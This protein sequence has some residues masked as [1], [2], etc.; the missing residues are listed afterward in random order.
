MSSFW[1]LWISLITIFTI[2]ASFWLLL[3]NR[4]ESGEKETTGHVYDGIEEYN[5]PL[6]AWWLWMFILTLIF[7]I[8]YLIA[9]PGLGNFKGVLNWSQISEYESEV[10]EAT[11]K[12]EPLFDEYA[13]VPID[14]LIGNEKAMRMGQR[15][16]ANNC[17]QCHGSDARGTFGFPNLADNDWLYGGAPDNIV[18]GIALG[19]TGT[20]PAWGPMLSDEQS[21][22]VVQHVR[23][24]SGLDD[25]SEA[26]AQV[27]GMFCQA[28]H[29]P[30]AKGMQM[31][32]APDLTDDIWLYGSS[33]ELISNAVENGLSGLMPAHNELLTESRIHLV[34]AYV[35][36]LSNKAESPPAENE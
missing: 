9:Y 20:M 3:G 15:L 1:S 23:S 35:Y 36:S 26:G 8:G 19:R 32:G 21:A 30:D 17:S 16:F 18:Q 7:G 29:G 27:F 4:K 34:A 28:C 10:A 11:A 2:I 12:Y 6:P 14:E 13:A 22:D 5:N 33:A 24:L 25:A 31:L